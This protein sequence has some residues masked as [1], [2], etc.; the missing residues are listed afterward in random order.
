MTAANWVLVDHPGLRRSLAPH[1]VVVR[2]CASFGLPGVHRV[3][4]PS[5]DRLDEVLAAFAAVAP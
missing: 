3:A 2:D 1:G 5:P 4:L